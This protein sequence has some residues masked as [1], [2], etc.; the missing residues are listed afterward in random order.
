LFRHLWFKFGLYVDLVRPRAGEESVQG[1]RRA[2]RR[3]HGR[4]RQV[5]AVLQGGYRGPRTTWP[6]DFVLPRPAVLDDEVAIA[7]RHVCGGVR[8]PQG[9][10]TVRPLPG[11]ACACGA[12]CSERTP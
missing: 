12:H 7:V 3:S 9:T 8:R 10:E 11:V 6:L 2:V 4:G 1:L 5:D